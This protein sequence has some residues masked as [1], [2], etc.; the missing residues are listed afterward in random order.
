MVQKLREVQVVNNQY[1]R[2][3]KN[4]APDT[5]LS[6]TSLDNK[7]E[8]FRKNDQCLQSTFKT[9]LK[10]GGAWLSQLVECTTHDLRFCEFKFQVGCGDTLNLKKKIR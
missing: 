4:K 9:F 8:T 3:S 5:W 2:S 7:V 10:L 6:Y 1:D